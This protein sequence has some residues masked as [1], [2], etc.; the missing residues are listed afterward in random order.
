[1][2]AA[3]STRR[4][5]YRSSIPGLD[6]WA[7]KVDDAFS[8]NIEGAS[9]SRLVDSVAPVL[10][11]YPGETCT[12]QRAEGADNG[13]RDV[14]QD[15]AKVARLH[16]RPLAKYIGL[17]GAPDHRGLVMIAPAILPGSPHT[18]IMR[19]TA[20]ADATTSLNLFTLIHAY[21]P[22]SPKRTQPLPPLH[23]K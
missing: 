19:A 11:R 7:G 10:N 17:V 18:L 12:W 13:T 4:Q 2:A 5:Q 8:S 21:T 15:V 22:T 6:I 3:S 9:T 16:N 14:G 23:Q 20:A 1:M